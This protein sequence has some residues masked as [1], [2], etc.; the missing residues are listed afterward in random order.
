MAKISPLMVLPP[1]IF[2]AFVGLAGVSMMRDDPD[3]LPSIFIGRAAPALP[4]QR[5]ADL[6]GLSREDL[7]TGEITVINFWASW[8]PPCRAEHPYLHE[9]R[10]RGV[11]LYGVNF[12]DQQGQALRY[13][14]DEGNPFLGLGFDPAGRSA[15]DWGVTAPPETFIIGGDGTVLF[16]FVGPLV[17]SDMEQRFEPELAKALAATGGA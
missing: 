4:E 12:K 15:I 7:T 8:C 11:R 5:L 6:P 17:G 14:E 10:E 3:S 13:L 2:L 9:L 1:L 16:K